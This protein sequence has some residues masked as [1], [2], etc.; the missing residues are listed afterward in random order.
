MVTL[1][2][3]KVS[4]KYKSSLSFAQRRNFIIFRL[5]GMKALLN[6]MATDD[7]V[8]DSEEKVLMELLDA[9]SFMTEKF[10]HFTSYEKARANFFKI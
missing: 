5:R 2:K 8:T 1:K 3:R 10:A 9:I 6:N 4:T 7:V